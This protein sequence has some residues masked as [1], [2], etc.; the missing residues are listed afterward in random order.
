MK[1]LMMMAAVAGFQHW[2]LVDLQSYTQK[3]ASEMKTKTS[4]GVDLA[5]YGNHWSQMTRRT[6]DGEAEVHASVSDVFICVQG[7]A[8]LVTGG[9]VVKSR[10]EGP[11]ETRGAAI[12][13]GSRVTM[14]AGDMVHIPAGLPHQLLV[15]REFLY[16]V[17]KVQE[18]GPRE[19]KGFAYWSAAE[20]AGY[21]A[22]LK[23]KLE[24]KNVATASLANWETHSFM[25]VYRTSDG[26]A[27]VHEGQVDYF[28]IIAGESEVVVGGK[29]VEARETGPGEI[30]GKGIAGG[31]ATLMKRGG[32]A[33]IPAA[34]PHQART[35]GELLY[36][37]LKVRQ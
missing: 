31:T 19:A 3:F 26:E 29:A 7:E 12:E 25:M 8:V 18:A 1:L 33:H 5:K 23:A 2:P 30:R 24:G 28:W 22:K 17:T 34:T 9:T 10:V 11:G 27:E 4:Y 35:K 36:A 37:V 15:G 6:A 13:G 14:R 32:V 16:F 20:L 21:G